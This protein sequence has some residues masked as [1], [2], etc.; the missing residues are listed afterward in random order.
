M[1]AKKAKKGTKDRSGPFEALRALKDELDK[2]EREGPPKKQAPAAPARVT[3]PRE[4]DHD[5]LSFHRLFGG[6]TPLD[7]SRAGRL[8]RDRVEPSA[9]AEHAATRGAA[10]ARADVD[11]VH[12]R[13]RALVDATARFEVADD[14][15]HVEGRRVDV[16]IGELRRLRRGSLP[17][18]GRVD[19]HGM[20]VAEAR[21]RLE[22]FLRTE[23]ARGERCV[24]V[25]HGRGQHS[26]G[27]VAVLRGEVSTWLSQG[28]CSAHVAA[29]ATARSDDGGK[30]AMYV[31]LRK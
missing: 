31:L 15:E 9:A 5:L 11:A 12:E 4:P 30:G 24:L 29:F 21:G 22:V 2:K 13:L 6:V 28:P 16:P 23:R 3:K 10:A 19:L 25:I 20:S 18:D 8:P 17:I 26:A 1:S 27:G 7:R 14:G